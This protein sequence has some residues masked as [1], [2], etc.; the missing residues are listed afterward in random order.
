MN[1][2]TTKFG[3]FVSSSPQIRRASYFLLFTLAL[4]DL[5]PLSMRALGRGQLPR[6]TDQ[7]PYF[8]T[9][10]RAEIARQKNSLKFIFF[11]LSSDWLEVSHH[12]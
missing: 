6:K 4:D 11:D 12:F 3:L 5:R 7:F 1:Y 2:K 10:F 9:N 8:F